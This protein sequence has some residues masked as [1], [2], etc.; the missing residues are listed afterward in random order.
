MI[1]LERVSVRFIE[2][3]QWPA[4]KSSWQAYEK[5]KEFSQGFLEGL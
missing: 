5:L 4:M 1:C 3:L 2:G